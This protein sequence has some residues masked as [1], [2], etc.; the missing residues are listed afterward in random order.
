MPNPK[1]YDDTSAG[2]FD[3]ITCTSSWLPGGGGEGGGGL[4]GGGDGGGGLGGGLGGGG[5]N[6]KLTIIELTRS[7]NPSQSNSLDQCKPG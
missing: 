6:M 7:A 3:I 4:G 2:A 1:E 5:A